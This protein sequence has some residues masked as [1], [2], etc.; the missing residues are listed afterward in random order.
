M[1]TYVCAGL[2]LL[3]G[4]ARADGPAA[5]Y[6]TGAELTAALNRAA[7][8]MLTAPVS[9]D[10]RHRINLVKRTKAAGAVAH[11]GFAELHHI[12]DGSGTLVTGGTLIR[13]TASGGAATIQDGVSRHV[14][15]GDVVLIPSGM[16][17]WYKDVEGTITYLEVRWAEK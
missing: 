4:L 3:T 14:A 7:P 13:P 11:D 8:D 15:K 6:K 2:L 12:V 10:D 5:T 16:P 1:K 17:H 9:I